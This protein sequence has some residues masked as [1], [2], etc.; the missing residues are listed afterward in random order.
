M[1][2][3]KVTVET[4]E[5]FR[6]TVECKMTLDA[7]LVPGKDN[8]NNKFKSTEEYLEGKAK[9]MAAF[10]MKS[11]LKYLK[12]N[13]FLAKRSAETPYLCE[14]DSCGILTEEIIRVTDIDEAAKWMKKPK[15]AIKLLK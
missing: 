8:S 15:K 13:S 7:I 9:E 3:F 5:G 10:C 11:L 6:K 1:A 2:K 14:L 4:E 12:T